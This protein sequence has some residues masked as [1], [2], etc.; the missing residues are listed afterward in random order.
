MLLT[1]CIYTALDRLRAG[2]PWGGEL[3]FAPTH[4]V[5]ALEEYFVTPPMGPPRGAL[6]PHGEE[7]L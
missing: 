1:D 7:L 6:A 5:P 2:A 3:D 4:G